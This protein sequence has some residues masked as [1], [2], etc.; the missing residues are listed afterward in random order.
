MQKCNEM[1]CEAT[2]NLQKCKLSLSITSTV[3]CFVQHSTAK[4]S[5]LY[6]QTSNRMNVFNSSNCSNISNN[7]ANKRSNLHDK[8]Q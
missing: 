6:D 7:L 2:S 4:I 5:A 8:L 3:S 1:T